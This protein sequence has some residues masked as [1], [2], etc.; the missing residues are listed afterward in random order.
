M[1]AA[2]SYSE[3]RLPRQTRTAD[4]TWE[5]TACKPVWEAG[6]AIPLSLKKKK[7]V[8]P[9]PAPAKKV[10]TISADDDDGMHLGSRLASML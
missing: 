7:T 3:F 1:D 2:V 9:A 6:A 4:G 8:A 5:A 10:W